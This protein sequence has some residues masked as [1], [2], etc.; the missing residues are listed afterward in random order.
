MSNTLRKYTSVFLAGTLL[1][2]G[3]CLLFSFP[4]FVSAQEITGPD[5]L[6][7]SIGGE[8]TFTQTTE[9]ANTDIRI[10]LGR[11][12]QIFLSIL[13]IIAVGLFLYAG[14]LWMTSGGDESKV[15]SAKKTMI[16][17]VIGIAIILS[18]FA[19]VQ[20]ILNALA[21]ATGFENPGDTTGVVADF[22]SFSGSGGLGAL[23]SDHY[24]FRDQRGVARNTK[25][26][27]TFRDE[28]DVSSITFDDAPVDPGLRLG[29]CRVDDSPFDWSSSCNQ[30]DT[31]VIQIFELPQ[32]I[33]EDEQ[34]L[35][36]SNPVEFIPDQ[37]VDAAVT[38]AY[39]GD[40]AHTFVFRPL[41]FIGKSTEPT[42]YCVRITENV[43]K[44]SGDTIFDR[45]PGPYTWKFGVSTELDL[46]P[47]RVIDTFPTQG[48]QVFRNNITSITFNEPID[49]TVAQGSLTGEAGSFE[50]VVFQQL[51]D[52]TVVTGAWTITN[53]YKTIEFLSDEACG[54]NSC[55]D[56]MFCMPVDS[57]CTDDACLTPYN[58]V[59]RTAAV[60][61]GWESLPFTGVGDM[62][63]NALDSAP[64]DQRD[65]KP[66]VGNPVWT[67]RDPAVFPDDNEY[68][69]DN[70]H[71]EF[72]V[73]NKIDFSVPAIIEVEPAVDAE[74]VKGDVPLYFTFSHVM[75]LNTLTDVLLVEAGDLPP[76]QE[77]SQPW[78][79]PRS[80]TIGSESDP[81][82][83]RTRTDI[84]HREF[85]PND[86]DLFYFMEIP[87]SVKANNQNCLYPGRGPAAA[88][89]VPSAD[90]V[91]CT[92]EFVDGDSDIVEGCVP[93]DAQDSF[94]DTGC[95]HNGDQT[96]AS[97]A[98]CEDELRRASGLAP[99]L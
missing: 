6:D 8:D 76:E 90:G 48:Q 2:V 21:D 10:I 88:G 69:P 11:I 54:N 25:I 30:L 26:V 78:H 66:T 45:T 50:H 73:Q 17:A 64:F 65:G 51:P 1:L 80:E 13:G 5:E 61:D 36:C 39:E 20:F 43:T 70:Y 44:I 84:E 14:F 16:N 94:N 82:G 92:Y 56:I 41:E 55:G 77:L 95:A 63:G 72:S 58:T 40:D 71:F 46:T 27:V 93:V 60:I 68:E 47:P 74:N 53:G 32:G 37:L 33:S 24:P 97:V 19:I 12:V 15:T 86:L 57:S 23:I 18:A 7:F 75:W 83:R 49:P 67:V 4:D 3:A 35:F 79:V 89:T 38:V 81:L 96:A 22:D 28:I 91:T 59:V 87:G 31:N 9:L 42:K 29:E 99:L 85:G 62:A 98:A 34:N 52:G